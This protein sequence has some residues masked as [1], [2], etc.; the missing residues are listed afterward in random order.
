MEQKQA[1]P[2]GSNRRRWI[3]TWGASLVLLL[4]VAPGQAQQPSWAQGV[5][6]DTSEYSQVVRLSPKVRHLSTHE[7]LAPLAWDTLRQFLRD[8]RVVEDSSIL[9]GLGYVVAGDDRRIVSGAGDRVYARGELQSG[10]RYGIYRMGERYIDT[11]SEEVLGLE[12]VSIG[13][14][15]V[16]HNEGGV[17]ALRLVSTTQEVRN[18]D[19]VLPLEE[20][21]LQGELH[22]RAPGHAVDGVILGAPDGVRFI[23]QLQVV[24]LDRGHRDGLEVGH[25]LAVKQ[26]GEEVVD[27][28]TGEALS[29]PGS[30]AGEVMLFQTYDKMSYG[31]VM[32]ATRSLAVGD[33]VHNPPDRSGEVQP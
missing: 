4:V 23:G 22:P 13:Q 25:V 15:Q 20:R 6:G 18:E 16:E 32:R 29:L 14:A 3:R 28:R 5:H 26:Q 7:A 19:I 17:A 8:H 27:P 1:L 31:L 21:E 9:E 33:R 11:T 30:D 2:Q 10:Q 12:L 24:A